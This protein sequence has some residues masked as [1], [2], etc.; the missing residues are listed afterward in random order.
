ML[1]DSL[2]KLIISKLASRFLNFREL[3]KYERIKYTYIENFLI[4]VLIMCS[5]ILTGY[6]ATFRDKSIC[7][8]HNNVPRKIPLFV[9]SLLL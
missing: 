8:P 7:A 4:L 9:I 5:F 3:E 2:S 1:S 6:K